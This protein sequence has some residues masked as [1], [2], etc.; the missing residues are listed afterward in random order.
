MFAE[1]KGTQQAVYDP[2]KQL[3]MPDKKLNMGAAAR[4]LPTGSLRGG[5]RVKTPPQKPT[6]ER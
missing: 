2:N 1:N 6:L 4:P 5:G 3:K